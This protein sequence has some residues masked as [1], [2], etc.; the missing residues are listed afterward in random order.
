MPALSQSLKFRPNHFPSST[1]TT[2]VVY[3]NTATGTIVF[4]SD[5]LKGD[6]YFG[7][8]DGLHTIMCVATTEFVGTVTM[9]ATLASEP[10]DGD[11]FSIGNSVVHYDEMDTRTTSTVD[12]VNF[13]GNFVWVRGNVAIDAGSVE[14]I[15]YN[16]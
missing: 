13:T 14:Y 2:E 3:P 5:K 11:W 9:Q 12:C 8:G 10:A 16:H 6:G 7:G 15:L 4:V 1:S